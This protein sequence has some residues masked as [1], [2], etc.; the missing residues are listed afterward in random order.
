MAAPEIVMAVPLPLATTLPRG[1][2]VAD[3][4]RQ[5]RV[6]PCYTVGRKRIGICLPTTSFTS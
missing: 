2:N 1:D 3:V 5:Q 6:S 4:G